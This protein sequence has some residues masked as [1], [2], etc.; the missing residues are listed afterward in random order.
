MEY[1]L[2]S[3]DTVYFLAMKNFTKREE[4][5]ESHFFGVKFSG[6]DDTFEKFYELLKSFFLKENRKNKNYSQTFKLG[7]K[8]VNLQY[9]PLITGKGI[10]VST[11][12]GYIDK[13]F[14][15]R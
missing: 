14:G 13:L 1:R 8:K 11:N 2:S 12:E 5:A 4:K 9:F 3:N 7:E 15:K 10:M 6:I